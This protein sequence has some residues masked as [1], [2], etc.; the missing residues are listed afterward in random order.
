MSK[1]QIIVGIFL[2]F[3][4]LLLIVF[5][6][7]LWTAIVTVQRELNT[8]LTRNMMKV[9]QG[10]NL[11]SYALIIGVSFIYGTLHSIG[12]G[13]GKAIISSYF[14]REE[15]NT[16]DALKLAGIVTLTHSGAALIL[17]ILFQTVLSTVKGFARIHFLNGFNVI[18]GLL[19]VVLGAYLIKKAKH[20]HEH[21]SDIELGQIGIYA[22][23]V[24][25]PVS[26]TILLLSITFNMYW[27]GLSSVIAL[28]L[29]MALVLFAL[30]IVVQKTRS[31]I[32]ID[33]S[34]HSHY[35]DIM[36]YISSGCIIFMG[37]FMITRGLAL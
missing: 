16:F 37:L 26:L 34:E 32:L 29:G 4:L 21:L 31:S 17:S 33:D 18:S 6:H 5:R 15:S 14:L 24:P 8:F 22:G 23:I 3:I 7:P 13:H 28:S 25:C 11:K 27:I 9:R 30:G 36:H 12:P 1:K 35:G 20:H 2:V 19:L 10:F